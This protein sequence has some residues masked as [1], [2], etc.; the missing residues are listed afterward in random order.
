[1]TEKQFGLTR[2]Q[3]YYN[4]KRRGHSVHEFGI[5]YVGIKSYIRSFIK[6]KR[7]ANIKN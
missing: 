6:V 5:K 3:K 4:F 1:M 2:K 7:M